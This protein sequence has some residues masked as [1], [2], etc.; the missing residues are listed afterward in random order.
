MH[1]KRGSNDFGGSAPALVAL[2]VGG[3]QPAG[4]GVSGHGWGASKG[5]WN[6]LVGN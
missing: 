4:S 2:P 6:P 1:S 5:V 3:P